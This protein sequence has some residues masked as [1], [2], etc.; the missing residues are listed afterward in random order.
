MANLPLPKQVVCTLVLPIRET[1]T[2]PEV[3]LGLGAKGVSL[4]R[5]NG[6]GGKLEPNDSSIRQRAIIELKE[7]IGI[8]A[9]EDALIPAAIMNF[10][11]PGEITGL[12]VNG[13]R[14]IRMYTYMVRSWQGKPA[15]TNEMRDPRWFSIT[16]LPMKDMLPDA[17][18]WYPLALQ[19]AKIEATI[20]YKYTGVSKADVR[21]VASWSEDF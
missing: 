5:R 1:R 4:N 2:E 17:N 9:A 14:H 12:G 7:E 16:A 6:F 21:Q 11:Y 13:A 3:L 15:E 19:G 8:A 10:D 20:T 18:L